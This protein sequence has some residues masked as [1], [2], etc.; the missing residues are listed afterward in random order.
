MQDGIQKEETIRGSKIKM[1]PSFRGQ[2]RGFNVALIKLVSSPSEAYGI[3]FMGQGDLE[4]DPS[5]RFLSLGWGKTS[6]S[7]G[8]SPVLQKTYLPVFSQSA[9]SRS[10]RRR[11]RYSEFCAGAEGQGPCPGQFG[12]SH[13][14]PTDKPDKKMASR[15]IIVLH[16]SDGTCISHPL[17]GVCVC[18]GDDGGPLLRQ[19]LEAKSDVLI[20]IATSQLAC[21]TY[22][23]PDLFT[24]ISEYRSWLVSELDKL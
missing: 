24:R 7:S 14:S 18:T 11:I 16:T 15:V 20:G 3:R 22:S 10:M 1:H 2:G 13:L 21:G 12:A 8:F 19:G 4:L 6:Q 17:I 23:K 9:C 5:E